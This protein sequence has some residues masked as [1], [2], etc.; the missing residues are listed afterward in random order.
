MA[1]PF[2]VPECADLATRHDRRTRPPGAPRPKAPQPDGDVAQPGGP[3]RHVRAVSRRRA[4]PCSAPGVRPRRSAG[5]WG[6]AAYLAGD[7][8]QAGLVGES[9]GASVPSTLAGAHPCTPGFWGAD[10]AAVGRIPAAATPVPTRP[11]G[12]AQRGANRQCT[13]RHEPAHQPGAPR[14]VSS[15]ASA[16]LPQPDDPVRRTGALSA[17]LAASGEVTCR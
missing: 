8:R 6:S 5:W 10:P 3:A 4:R 11:H 1:G 17:G 15:P 9:A 13:A 12:G 14:R 16:R 2:V 7:G